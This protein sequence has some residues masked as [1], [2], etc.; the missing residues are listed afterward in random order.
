MQDIPL[1]R[2]PMKNAHVL[3]RDW[4]K[5]AEGVVKQ[6]YDNMNGQCVYELLTKHLS[7]SSKRINITKETLLET[8]Q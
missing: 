7:N 4:L 6:S 1:S 8:F 5:Y 2:I 3:H